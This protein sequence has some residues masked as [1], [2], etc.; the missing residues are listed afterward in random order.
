M[1]SWPQCWTF[2]QNRFSTRCCLLQPDV[3]IKND[4]AL[5]DR[6]H[7]S[8]AVEDPDPLVLEV[9]DLELDD[10]DRLSLDDEDMYN[11]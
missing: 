5:W 10:A 8:C 11:L 2:E 4:I 6:D 9:S 3:L 7:S 1:L